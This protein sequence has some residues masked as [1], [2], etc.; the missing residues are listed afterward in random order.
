[1]AVDDNGHELLGLSLRW[2]GDGA[3]IW[4]LS[5]MQS[6]QFLSF[7]LKESGMVSRWQNKN[8]NHVMSLAANGKQGLAQ[9]SAMKKPYDRY[10]N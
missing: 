5:V 2:K 7:L 4:A 1:M 9:S 3:A 6:R 8:G 10:I